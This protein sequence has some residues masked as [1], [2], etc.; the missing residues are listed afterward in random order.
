MSIQDR[1]S[2]IRVRIAD[3]AAVYGRGA[4][5]ICLIAVS[6]THPP[7]AVLDAYSL[8]QRTFGEN[9]ADEL[10]EKSTALQHL[11]DIKWV[12]IG[13]LQSNKIQK[14]VKFADEIQSIASEK[15]ARYVQ[16]YAAE[17]G[18]QHFPVWIVV[19]AAAEASKQGLSF[20]ELAKLSEFIL[21]HCPNLSLQGIMAIP[22][23][24]F[25]DEVYVGEGKPSPPDLYIKLRKAASRTGLGK[26]S[27]G[28]TGDLQIAIA[29]GR[30]C[31]RIGT[32][33]FGER[34]QK[35]AP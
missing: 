9:Y 5:E 18:K 3:A 29:A 30:D 19:N 16:R 33:I 35:Q 25:S 28:M 11:K 22:P 15:H 32:A 17:L 13:Q 21:S 14:I 24:E 4:S 2:A 6:K 31:V 23:A 26:L 7:E 27:L 20:D 12:F 34:A 10:A 8:G 1:L